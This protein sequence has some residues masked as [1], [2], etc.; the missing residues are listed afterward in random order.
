MKQAPVTTLGS[1]DVVI[2]T[3]NEE[4]H[5]ARAIQNLSKLTRNIFVID[6]YSSDRT[7]EIAR[8]LG[9]TV[10]QNKFVNQA[11]QFNWAL[12][13]APLSSEWVM[14]LDADEVLEPDLIQEIQSKLPQLG[15]E[16]TGINLKR[17][18]IFMAALD[19][20]RRSVSARDAENLAARMCSS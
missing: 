19:Q 2:L 13:N 9:A 14:R 17:K 16:I 6:S 11:K 1:I 12:D 8:S 18:H 5:I 3:Y 20:T 15:P 7:V 10:L 4:V